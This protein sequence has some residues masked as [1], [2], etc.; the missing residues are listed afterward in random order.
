MPRDEATLLDIV[1]AAEYPER[2]QQNLFIW[3]SQSVLNLSQS[4]SRFN[5]RL[6]PSNLL[7]EFDRI[8]FAELVS[9]ESR[10]WK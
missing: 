2:R 10:K 8:F 7:N 3:N 6:L 5:V 9:K 1:H 4:Y